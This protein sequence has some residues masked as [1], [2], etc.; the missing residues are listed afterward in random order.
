M[1]DREVSAWVLANH[2]KVIAAAAEATIARVLQQLI[3]DREDASAVNERR[4][5]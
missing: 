2:E 4:R 3:R 5:Q 1:K